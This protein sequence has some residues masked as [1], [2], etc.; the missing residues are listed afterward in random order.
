[1]A[2]FLIA[3]GDNSLTQAGHVAA[4]IGDADW[5]WGALEQRAFDSLL[6]D[7]AAA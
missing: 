7:I 1:M 2:R 6:T 3:E 4:A 5:A